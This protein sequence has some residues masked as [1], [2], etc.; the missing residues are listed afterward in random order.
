MTPNPTDGRITV[1]VSL[2][3]NTIADLTVLSANGA[4]VDVLMHRK[5]LKGDYSFTSFLKP[6]IEGTFFVVL[7]TNEGMLYEK[8]MLAK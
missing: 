2:D 4:A 5:A 8:V 6:E 7:K 3:N 1:Q